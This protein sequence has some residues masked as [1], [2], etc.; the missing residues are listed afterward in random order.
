MTGRPHGRRP[1][2]AL[3]MLVAVADLVLLAAAAGPM[4]MFSIVASLTV[5]AGAVLAARL[6]LTKRA[7]PARSDMV[8]RRRA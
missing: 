5:L 1:A 8:L 4:V 6:L 3:W 7:A 2:L